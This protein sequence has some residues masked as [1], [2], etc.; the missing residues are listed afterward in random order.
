MKE[1]LIFNFILL[2]A[3]GANFSEGGFCSVLT[4]LFFFDKL[5]VHLGSLFCID[6][7]QAYS[8]TAYVY[9]VHW[10]K[11]TPLANKH[12]TKSYLW[13][14]LNYTVFVIKLTMDNHVYSK[15]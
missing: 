3:F 12:E 7:P 1:R 15:M 5:M 8:D 13:I 14:L 6:P 9:R 10:L 11:S 2:F 4:N